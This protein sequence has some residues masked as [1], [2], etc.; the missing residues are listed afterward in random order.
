MASHLGVPAGGVTN[1]S[2]S[3]PAR[4]PVPDSGGLTP[5]TFFLTETATMGERC[6]TPSL[7]RYQRPPRPHSKPGEY[8][9]CD[10][11]DRSTDDDISD[12]EEWNRKLKKLP[13]K[14]AEHLERERMKSSS[15]RA[16]RKLSLWQRRFR[17]A[18]VRGLSSLNSLLEEREEHRQFACT[19]RTHLD[20]MTHDAEEVGADWL[21][22]R[23]QR[24]TT[25]HHA[26]V[27]Q[28][29]FQSI[30]DY[31]THVARV[32]DIYVTL[33]DKAAIEY[34]LLSQHIEIEMFEAI[35]KRCMQCAELPD[36]IESRSRS[37]T[38]MSRP[39]SRA[40]TPAAAGTPAFASRPV[41]RQSNTTA[42]DPLNSTNRSQQS[43]SRPA[44]ST[45][46][47]RSRRPTDNVPR[48][49]DS[50]PLTADFFFA[51]FEEY[52]HHLVAFKQGVL[53][54]NYL[55]ESCGV[56][57]KEWFQVIQRHTQEGQADWTPCHEAQLLYK[58]LMSSRNALPGGGCMEDSIG[59]PNLKDARR[60]SSVR[61]RNS[62]A[63]IKEPAEEGQS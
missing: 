29:I 50:F 26:S 52:G 22:S 46:F 1:S 31:E 19:D 51:L 4:T 34:G 40:A 41:S 28:P 25:P 35:R 3:S 10:C 18:T 61:R 43:Q 63:T 49:D 8:N 58:R 13:P 9:D 48:P 44:S 23:R 5:D 30:G 57:V 45:S 39:A 11:T 38:P 17:L 55:R 20:K 59:S 47:K 16:G 62:Q 2:I 53:F 24:S 56:G 14:E 6:Q 27:W 37:S 60:R 32:R 36:P 33:C 21:I 12:D 42:R 54:T 15:L 7:A